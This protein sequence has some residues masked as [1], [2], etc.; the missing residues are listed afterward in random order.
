MSTR[1]LKASDPQT[2]RARFLIRVGSLAGA[3]IIVRN[4][5]GSKLMAI[6]DKLT[7]DQQLYATFIAAQRRG[8]TAQ[9][10]R[11]RDGAT[12]RMEILPPPQRSTI[13]QPLV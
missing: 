5:H 9:F 10:Q 1:P 8:C 6:F 3:D 11:V 7:R 2:K 13:Y 4:R 12:A